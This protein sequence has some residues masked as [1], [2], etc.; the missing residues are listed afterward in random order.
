M[1]GIG[2][3]SPAEYVTGESITACKDVLKNKLEQ[4]L[5]GRDIRMRN[6]ICRYI[7]QE[8][9][10]TPAARTAID[11]ALHDLMAKHLKIP[12]VD[13]LGRSYHSLPTSITIGIKSLEET[14]EEAEEY[15]GR[16]FKIIK[17]KIGQSADQDIE[18]TRKLREKVGDRMGIRVD[19][20]QGYSPDDLTKYAKETAKLNLELIEQP[21]P[22]D[23]PA[24]MLEFTRRHPGSL[25]RR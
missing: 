8:L 11:I 19:A 21:V 1:F 17:L 20:N 7:E 13:L 18:I 15:E 23:Q 25:R 16:G 3:G 4:L 14:L 2:A 12:L 9:P 10:D 22:R 6:S 24:D 5:A